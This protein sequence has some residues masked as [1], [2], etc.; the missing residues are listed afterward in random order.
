AVC[1]Q[2][3]IMNRPDRQEPKTTNGRPDGVDTGMP[4]YLLSR[5]NFVVTPGPVTLPMRVTVLPGT[6]PSAW[7]PGGTARGGGSWAWAG[8]VPALPTAARPAAAAPPERTVRRV[9]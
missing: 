2:S 9:G 1:C 7:A 6:L 3:C 5:S 4:I 8:A